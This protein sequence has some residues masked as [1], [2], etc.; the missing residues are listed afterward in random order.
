MKTRRRFYLEKTFALVIS[1]SFASGALAQSLAT[2]WRKYASDDGAYSVKVPPGWHAGGGNGAVFLSTFTSAESLHGVVIPH[3][4]A[5]I[6]VGS[7]SGDSSEKE[8]WI[9]EGTRYSEPGVQ[10]R[11]ITLNKPLSG[12]CESLTRIESKLEVGPKTYFNESTFYCMAG[13]MLASISL[14]H[15]DGDASH[16]KW[17]GIALEVAKSLVFIKSAVK[18]R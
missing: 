4:G 6:R 12:S 10:R 13:T 15:W 3:H 1:L 2:G 17:Q 16:A 7:A 14:T 9:R 5:Q 8:K 18:P 11:E